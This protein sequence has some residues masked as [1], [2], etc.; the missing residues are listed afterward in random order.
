[1]QYFPKSIKTILHRIFSYALLHG[2]SRILLHKVLTCAKLSQEYWDNISED[3]SYAMLSGAS[4]TTW[5][6]FL[7]VQCCPKGIKAKLHRTFL[8]NVIWSLSNNMV[9]A[10][11][12][13][14]LSQEYYDNI[15]QSF[16]LYKV[17]WSFLDNIAEG[18]QLCNVVSRVLRQFCTTFFLC[19][20]AW[21]LSDI[22]A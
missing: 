4:R 9:W 20:V 13:T 10:L 5:Q 16:F 21:S 3:F 1:M 17:V 15:S 12:C 11:T 2:T 18:F 6:G 8:C 22:I 7:L 19:I 14:K